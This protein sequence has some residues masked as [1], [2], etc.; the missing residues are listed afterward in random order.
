MACACDRDRYAG[1]PC[2]TAKAQFYT[3]AFLHILYIHRNGSGNPGLHPIDLWTSSTDHGNHISQRGLL[4]G[5]L[6]KACVVLGCSLRERGM[7]LY[8]CRTQGGLEATAD[9][10]AMCPESAGLKFRDGY[11]ARC[12]E[13]DDAQSTTLSQSSNSSDRPLIRKSLNSRSILPSH[14]KTL[15]ARSESPKQAVQAAAHKTAVE[16]GYT[17]LFRRKFAF[18]NPRGSGSDQ[19]GG[20][21]TPPIV[22]TRHPWTVSDLSEWDRPV[23]GGVYPSWSENKWNVEQMQRPN[24]GES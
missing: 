4:V 2:C 1:Q 24:K 3:S 19:K 5:S 15:A 17:R 9:L 6:N 18:L 13:H 21:A 23:P 8:Y 7:L 14:P 12:S 20:I 22:L 16:A 10:A 11:D